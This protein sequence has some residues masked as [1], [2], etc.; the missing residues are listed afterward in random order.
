MSS[1]RFTLDE[2]QNIDGWERF[3][4]SLYEKGYKI[5]ITGS[6][7]NL[8][9]K[10]L[11]THLTGRYMQFEVYPLSFKEIIDH[12]YPE[13]FSKNAHSTRMTGNILHHF[14]LY[15]NIWWYP[16]VCPSPQ[17]LSIYEIYLRV[18]SIAI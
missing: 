17:I 12:N 10:E 14:C 4:R 8:L 13:I 16:R 2:I 6:N 1:Q 9:S 11:G 3:I 18:S 5:F 15:L 7:A